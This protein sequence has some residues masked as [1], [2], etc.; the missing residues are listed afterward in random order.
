MC[1][2]VHMLSYGTFVLTE[3]SGDTQVILKFNLFLSKVQQDFAKKKKELEEKYQEQLVSMFKIGTVYEVLFP[4]A[5]E[6]KKRKTFFSHTFGSLGASVGGSGHMVCRFHHHY[7]TY[8]RPT[9]LA[10]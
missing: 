10:C 6:R 1:F 5:E 8:R 9:L 3:Q 4:Q 2:E 7:L